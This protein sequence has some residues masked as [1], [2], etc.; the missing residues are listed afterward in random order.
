MSYIIFE[1]HLNENDCIYFDEQSKV[2]AF[3]SE[4][5]NYIILNDEEY[6]SIGYTVAAMDIDYS[7]G[8]ASLNADKVNEIL[9]ERIKAQ[10]NEL[11]LQSDWM[12]SQDRVMSQEEKDYRQALRDITDQDTF[13]QAVTWPELV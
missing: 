2:D 10:R 7:A 12:A 3:V 13:P 5:T 1:N 11:L 9:S 6:T 8:T 4:Q